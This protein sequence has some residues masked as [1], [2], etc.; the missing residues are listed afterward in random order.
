MRTLLLGGIALLLG[1]CSDRPS[2]VDAL[3]ET[4]QADAS[5]EWEVAIELDTGPFDSPQPPSQLQLGDTV[6]ATPAPPPVS[7]GTMLVT[8]DGATAVVADPDR[9]RVVLVDLAGTRVRATVSLNPGDEPGRVVEH[10]GRAYVALR[11]GG[12]VVAIDLASGA[13]LGRTPVCPAPR[14]LAFDGESLWVAC[15]GGELVLDALASKRTVRLDRD[16]RD[17]VVSG[18]RRYVTTFRT[19]EILTLDPN[20]AVLG[21]GRPDGTGSGLAQ[22]TPTVAYRAIARPAGGLFVVHQR[23]RSGFVT[24]ATGGYGSGRC[25]PVEATVAVFDGATAPGGPAIV[26]AVLPLDLALSPDGSRIAVVAPGGARVAGGA[27]L[28]VAPIK[29]FAEKVDCSWPLA[30][31]RSAQLNG[32]AVAV[33]W[34]PSGRLLVQSREPAVLFLEDKQIELGGGSRYDTGHAIFHAASGVRGLEVAGGIACASCHA[35]GGDDGV[36]WEFEGLGKRRTQTFRGGLSGT[37]PFHWDGSLPTLRALVDEVFHKRMGGPTLDA[38]QLAAL[39]R[40]LDAIPTL[41]RSPGD[42]ATVTRGKAL[43]EGEAQQCSSCHRGPRLTD[44]RTVDVG[45][46]GAFQTASLIGL[47]S[48]APFLHDGCARTLRDRFVGACG[49][50]ERHGR[51]AH[52]SGAQITDL[53]A[54]LESL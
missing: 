37:A 23:A 54:Y 11:R 40:Y 49:G 13:L 43:F 19:A 8:A 1:A 28:F 22:F 6:V 45:T 15:N 17:V 5:Q 21:R 39:A 2:E 31:L 29:G 24:V 16:L 44:N 50:A 32:E 47:S 7:G 18:G 4:G 9:D 48:H 3:L 36:T 20:G 12:A 35:E 26:G 38:P 52:L 14:G 10:A 34:T 30:E 53:V 46:G 51:T 41:P 33:A 27:Q 25:G 42:A